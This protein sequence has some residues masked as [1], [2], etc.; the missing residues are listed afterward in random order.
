MLRLECT[1]DL[2]HGVN[3]FKLHT[4]I[5]LDNLFLVNYRLHNWA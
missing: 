3:F 1:A 5:K 2:C 4:K